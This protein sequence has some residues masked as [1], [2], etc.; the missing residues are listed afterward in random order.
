MAEKI[1]YR[2]YKGESDLPHIMALVQSEL[3]EPYVVYTFRYFLHE[4]PHLSFLAYP[5]STS[6]EPI[7]AIVCKQSAH[8]SISNRG[9]IAMLS[10]DKRW[11][12]RG[13]ASSLV[14]HSIEAMKLGGVDEIMLETEYDNHAAL[15]LYESLG[16]I[17]EK[18]LYRFYLNGKDAFRLILVIPPPPSRT[19]SDS[20]S[21]DSSTSPP[22]NSFI[23]QHRQRSMWRAPPY[24][25]IPVIPYSDDEDDD[26]CSSR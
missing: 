23:H 3:S 9:Y 16:F 26:H 15:S 10:V 11:R 1:V 13:I 19:D 8:K 20:S 5:D 6:N 25:A 2:Q 7:G 18:R 17:R 4:W 24:R 21:E 22:T 14:R 12:K